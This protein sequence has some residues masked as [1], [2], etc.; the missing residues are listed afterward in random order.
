MNKNELGLIKNEFMDI[1]HPVSTLT[2]D[3]ILNGPQDSFRPCFENLQCLIARDV[4]DQ[5]AGIMLSDREFYEAVKHLSHLKRINGL[6]MEIAYAR[7][8]ITAPDAWE[9]IK[10]FPYYPNYLGLARMEYEGANLKPGDRVV[11]L[12]SGPV[13]LSLISLCKQYGLGGVGIEKVQEYADLSTKLIETLGLADH[14]RILQGNHFS[15]PIEKARLLIMV[16]ADAC[17]KDEIFAHLAKTVPGGTKISYRI[18]EKGLRRLMDDQ[19]VAAIPPEFEE[20]TR[21]RPKPPVN[22]TSVFLIKTSKA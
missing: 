8:I 16:G 7:S 17:P 3:E 1:Y 2:G 4:D 22:N 11:F 6:R 15:I 12:G 9:H 5:A 10:R 18:Y 19:P 14:I 21:I 13:P 20:Y